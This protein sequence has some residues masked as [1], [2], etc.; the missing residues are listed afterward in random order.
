MKKHVVTPDEF[1][2][3]WTTSATVDEVAAR[4]KLPKPI[5]SARASAY[6]RRGVQLK[7]MRR[8][9]QQKLNVQLLNDLIAA[10]QQDETP[11]DWSV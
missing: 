6:R 8:G 1:V 2:V 10:N 9:N 3:A 11:P 5:V 7:K 4:L